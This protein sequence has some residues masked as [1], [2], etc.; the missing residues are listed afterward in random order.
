MLAIRLLV[1]NRHARIHL[2]RLQAVRYEIDDPVCTTSARFADMQRPGGV[3]WLLGFL[4]VGN[5][6]LVIGD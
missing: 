6:F 4:R 5:C 1:S 3:A 2:L